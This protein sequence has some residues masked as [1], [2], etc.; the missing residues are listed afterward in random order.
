MLIV[1][2]NAYGHGAVEM[3][4]AANHLGIFDF[5]VATLSEA[6][7]LRQN[8]VK[9][10]I[11]ILGQVDFYDITE[12]SKHNLSITISSLNNIPQIIDSDST[13]KVH[14]KIDTGMSRHGLYMHNIDNIP[15]IV[16]IIRQISKNQSIL[17]EGIY[18]HFAAADE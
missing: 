13:L 17:I 2:A 18:T 10:N 12:V 1:K 14:V 5:G 6:I 4:I 8:N 16:S 15:N 11:L 3:A 7:E 9:G